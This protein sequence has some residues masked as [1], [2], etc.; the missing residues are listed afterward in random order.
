MNFFSYYGLFLAKTMTIVIAILFILTL[1]IYAKSRKRKKSDTLQI[2]QLN[3]EYQKIKESLLLS[4]LE[5]Y[6]K[7][8]FLKKIKKETK[9]NKKILQKTPKPTL[10]VLDFRGGINAE[11]VESLRKEISAILSV[12]QKNDQV[13]LRLESSGGVVHGYGLAASQLQRLRDN[14]LHLI[15]TVDKIAASGGYLMA[16]VANNLIAAPFAIIGS[17][18]VVA[19]IPNFHRFLKRNNIDIEL[20]T[21][22]E[23]KRTLTM[24][25]ENTDS[26]RKKF[27]EN[28]E[29]THQLF[30][31]FVY[32][33]RPQ[34]NM[35]EVATG[36]YWFGK[37][38]FEKGLVDSLKTSDDV[39]LS[40]L[41]DFNI[42]KIRYF[43][44]KRMID[45][46]IYNI[47]K[48]YKYFI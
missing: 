19:Q 5:I 21:A 10:Y 6:E 37:Q 46:F 23:Y 20:H 1:I 35:E 18:G 32:K 25:G 15:I 26:N 11:E 34:L 45:R 28:L 22:G 24:F 29:Q 4:K 8:I 14:K 31:N 42:I 40:K 7:K 13:L 17:I 47:E 41:S 27:V 16:C 44:R 12:F 33:M 38:A 9:K 3:K 43:K 36:E 48:C 39:I 30:K 2:I